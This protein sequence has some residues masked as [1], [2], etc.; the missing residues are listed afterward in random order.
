[1]GDPVKPFRGVHRAFLRR[2]WRIYLARRWIDRF[3]KD[4]LG[5]IACADDGPNWLVYPEDEIATLPSVAAL[6][7]CGPLEI[8]GDGCFPI[9]SALR[10]ETLKPGAPLLLAGQGPYFAIWGERV[11]WQTARESGLAPPDYSRALKV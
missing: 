1:M 11:F 4:A 3:P 5:L 10:H 7:R 8:G 6:G 9:P 2:G